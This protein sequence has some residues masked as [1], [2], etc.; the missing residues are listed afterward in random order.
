MI[1]LSHARRLVLEGRDVLAPC[2][3][4]LSRALGHV[5]AAPV[6]SGEPVPP[7]TNSAMD[8]YALRAADTDGAPTTLRVV[9]AIMAGQD[10]A[11]EVRPGEAVRIMTGAPVPVG[12]DAVCM[13]ERTA[14]GGPGL[15]RIAERVEQGTNIRMAGGDVRVGQEVFPAGTV[16]SPAHLGAL[17]S[18]GVDHVAVVPRPQVGVVSTGDELAPPGSPLAPG[19][20]HDANRPGLLAQV[21]VDGWG[22]CDLGSVG[23]DQ[24]A[25]AHLLDQ[26]SQACD[27]VMASGGVSVGDRDVVKAALGVLCGQSAHSLQV[28]IKPAKPLAF[29]IHAQTG[30][31]IFGLPG[32]PVSALVS[33]ELFARP[34]LR[35]MAGHR[36]IDRPVLRATTVTDL[37]RKP[38]GKLHFV[39][40]VA[41]VAGDGSLE[42]RPSG[43]QDSHMLRAMADAN[44]LG[45]LPDGD[46]VGAG[47]TVAVMLLDA[48]RLGVPVAGDRV[49]GMW[50][51]FGTGSR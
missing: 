39:R 29:G 15:V 46:G 26:A 4:E 50:S 9:G 45:V 24:D 1:P 20:I 23:D 18:I 17:A 25:V 30:T 48:D 34:L 21:A 10:G 19:M 13:V 33:Y 7:F 12:A 16:L 5:L 22:A 14:P 36:R 51:S 31:P 37:P 41:T 6:V 43:G 47:G 28:A 42:V 40:M 8:G 44:A 32:N 2:T 3:M 11:L 49:D 35:R 27:V 38:D